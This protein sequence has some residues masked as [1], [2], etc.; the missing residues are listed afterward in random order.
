MKQLLAWLF[1]F[2]SLA[3][4]STAP[5]EKN[6]IAFDSDRTGNFEIFLM[7][8]NGFGL[9]QLTHDSQFDSWWPKISPNRSEILFYRTPKGVHDRDYSKTSLWLMHADGSDLHEMRPAGTG[10]WKLQGHAEWSPDGQHLVMFGGAAR[11]PQIYITDI[12]GQNPLQLTNR[13]GQNLDPSWAPDGKSVLFIGCPVFQCV[14]KNYEVYSISSS[15]NELARITNDSIRDGDPYYSPDGKWIAWLS[16]T[17]P[18]EPSTSWNIRILDKSRGKIENL[19]YDNFINGKP[20]WSLDGRTIYFHRMDATTK[21]KFQIFVI[22]AQGG[23][24]RSI[25]AGQPGNNEYPCS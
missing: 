2:P 7:R 16:R 3:F 8:A 6:V 19:T 9:R 10:D 1:L 21:G 23:P 14:E 4:A 18:S 17:G 22:P 15:G 13:G 12:Q 25:T 20:A 5:L 11:S 24:L